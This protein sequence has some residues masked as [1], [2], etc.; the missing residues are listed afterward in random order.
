MT[1][2]FSGAWERSMPIKD[3]DTYASSLREKFN[4][5]CLLSHDTES[6][7]P[8][9]SGT[10]RLLP[11]CLLRK[12]QLIITLWLQALESRPPLDSKQIF[13][14]SLHH[15]KYNHPPFSLWRIPETH[16][17]RMCVLSTLPAH[18]FSKS[19]SM[20]ATKESFITH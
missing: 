2:P 17:G 1:S 18:S 8:V 14:V 7:H 11:G 19:I 10:E 20:L 12:D 15:E 6:K 5:A 4:S 16:K 9:L 3:S 13:Q